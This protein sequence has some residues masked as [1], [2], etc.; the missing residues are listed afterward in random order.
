MNRDG[1]FKTEQKK[2]MNEVAIDCLAKKITIFF[3]FFERVK[4]KLWQTS[5][6][7]DMTAQE[8]QLWL[9]VITAWPNNDLVLVLLYIA[10]CVLRPK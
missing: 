9:E 2:K 3:F 4:C 7:A 8:N 6:R 1:V 5:H 10:V